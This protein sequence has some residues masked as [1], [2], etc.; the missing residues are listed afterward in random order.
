MVAKRGIAVWLVLISAEIVHGIA[1]GILLRP[2]VGD[3][4]ARQIGVFSGSVIFFAIALAFVRWI[5]A[6]RASQLVR[7]GALWL[8]LTTVFEVCFGRFVLGY[9]WER[10]RSDYDPSEGG[11][12]PVGLV[13]LALSPYVAGKVRGSV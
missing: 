1:R 6:T 11:L 4:R 13:L 8:V 12:L 10:I 2:Y 3:L 7:V 9:S 5:G